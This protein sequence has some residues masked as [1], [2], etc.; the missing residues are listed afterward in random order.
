MTISLTSRC[1]L[2]N[3]DHVCGSTNRTS[4]LLTNFTRSDLFLLRGYLQK[5]SYLTLLFSRCR[6]LIRKPYWLWNNSKTLTWRS[7]NI[8]TL[9][10]PFLPFPFL[11]KF[12][13]S[14]TH[15]STRALSADLRPDWARLVRGEKAIRRFIRRW[16]R[17]LRTVIVQLNLSGRRA[18]LGILR[19]LPSRVWESDCIRNSGVAV[20]SES[21]TLWAFC[22]IGASPYRSLT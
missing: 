15:L 7:P 22:F 10:L 6:Y 14:L 4:P 3:D 21:L 2:P 12:Y 11:F 17:A 18:L 8:S 19:L 9:I 16:G 20:G 1:L 5:T 13:F